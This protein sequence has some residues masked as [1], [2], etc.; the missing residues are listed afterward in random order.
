[1]EIPGIVLY[2]IQPRRDSGISFLLER[3]RVDCPRGLRPRKLLISVEAEPY[4]L[5]ED[6]CVLKKYDLRDP[7]KIASLVGELQPFLDEVT[8]TRANH[9]NSRKARPVIMNE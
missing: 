9:L 5:I 3:P 2:E 1:M 7:K 6:L 8:R 4:E